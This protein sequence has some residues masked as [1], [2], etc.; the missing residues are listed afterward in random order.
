MLT[1]ISYSASNYDA[2]KVCEHANKINATIEQILVR[3]GGSIEVYFRTQPE[4]KEQE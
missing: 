1:F 3:A 2:A 4:A